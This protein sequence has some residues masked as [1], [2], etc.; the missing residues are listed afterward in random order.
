MKLL[1]IVA[2]VVVT[3]CVVI[4]TATPANESGPWTGTWKFKPAPKSGWMPFIKGDTLELVQSGSKIKGRFAFQYRSD[5]GLATKLCYS[6][7]GG[8][9]VGS[10]VGRRLDARLVWPA[11][12]RYP[13]SVA[14]LKAKLSK[15]GRWFLVTE[16]TVTTGACGGTG[17]PFIGQVAVRVTP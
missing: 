17:A 9:A 5:R 4:A 13:R 11:E 12:G 16:G 15:N 3:A 1:S 10:A 14:T 6:P 2:M 7:I 8:Y